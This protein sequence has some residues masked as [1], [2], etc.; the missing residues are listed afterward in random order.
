MPLS[1]GI[2]FISSEYRATLSGERRIR[3]SSFLF[4]SS[5]T[6][7]PDRILS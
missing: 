3:A 2:R 4:E 5:R 6:G 1:A 7:N